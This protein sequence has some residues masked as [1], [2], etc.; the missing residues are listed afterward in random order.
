MSKIQSGGFDILDTMNPAEL[1]YKIVN[2]AKDLSNKVS[3]YNLVKI[4]DSSRKV[5]SD[6]K[7]YLLGH[8]IFGVEITLT[9]NEIKDTM[10]I[11][12]YPENR[13]ILLKVTTT[14]IAGQ[15][16][17]FLN[18]L[19]VLMTAGLPLMK[20][21]L[22]PLAK[23]VLLPFWLSAAMSATDAAIQK[24][25][26]GS[27]TT[28]LIISNEEME[29]IMKI[30]KSLEESGLL[31]KGRSETIKNEVKEQKGRFLWM[32][33][34]ILAASILGHALAGKGVIT[35]GQGVI[36]AGQDF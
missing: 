9:N 16:G 17:G 25:F 11:I 33:L 27:E 2:K 32:L 12:K 7:K 1:V 29:D 22:T 26:Y 35:T 19:K 14:K 4:A 28:A 5:L 20:I 6:P 8:A 3:L 15:K 13:G 24:P 18:F 34:G 36:R 31:I 30:A 23:S 10:K 21:V